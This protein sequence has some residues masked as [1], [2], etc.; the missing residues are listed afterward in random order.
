VYSVEF[1]L[2]RNI[3]EAVRLR[4]HS[5]SISV[6]KLS[7]LKT[8]DLIEQ[9]WRDCTQSPETEEIYSGQIEL[10]LPAALLKGD[11]ASIECVVTG[12]TIGALKIP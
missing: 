2:F 3:S 1:C 8:F 10:E 6:H 7:A 12:R 11:Y 4:Y 9:Q 5:G